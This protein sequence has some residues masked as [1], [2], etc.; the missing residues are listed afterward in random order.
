MLDVPLNMEPMAPFLSNTLVPVPCVFSPRPGWLGGWWLVCGG[1]W[2]REGGGN[3]RGYAH[4]LLDGLVDAFVQVCG[5][6]LSTVCTLLEGFG[7]VV[8][9]HVVLF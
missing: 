6:F 7:C 3:E 9:V 5:S 8:A 4:N 1:E 2:E